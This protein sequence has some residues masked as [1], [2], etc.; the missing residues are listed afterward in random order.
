MISDR[1]IAM[2]KQLLQSK[3]TFA[4]PVILYLFSRFGEDII[5]YEFDTIAECLRSIETKTPNA[6]IDR[7]NA[8]LGLFNSDLFW[9]NPV[10][11]SMVCR[12]LNRNP[13]PANSEPSLGDITWGVTEASLLFSGATDEESS[14]FS[15]SIQAFVKYLFKLNGVFT[16]PESLS[17]MGE[18]AM[19]LKIADAQIA[20]ARQKESDQAAARLEIFAAKQ[21]AELFKQIKLLNLPLLESAKKELDGIIKQYQELKVTA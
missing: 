20:I 15:P 6:L 9:V 14:Q 7:V 13:F 4:T 12:A 11:F 18:V 10:T 21:T 17:G 19:D 16:L 5:T 3:K 8:G 2:I 1:G